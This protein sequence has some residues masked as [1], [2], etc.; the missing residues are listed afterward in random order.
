MPR[1][2]VLYTFHEMN[3]RVQQ[4][5]DGI[6]QSPDVDF[7]VISNGPVVAV[8]PY[9]K[10]IR[11]PNIGHDFGAWSDGLLAGPLTYEYYI[12]VNSSA[13]G[14]WGP[15]GPAGDWTTRFIAGLRNGVKLFGS[16]INVMGGVMGESLNTMVGAHVQSYAFAMDREAAAFLIEKGI[17]SKDY[18]VNNRVKIVEMKEVRMSRLII[19]N[20][21]NIGCL[22][23]CYEGV[24]F[25][26]RTEYPNRPFYTDIMYPC[27]EWHLWQ[28]VELVFMKG[29]R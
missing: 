4:F 20:G 24:D 16:T 8:P 3:K 9:V 26:G 11:R 7:L 23:K 6:F 28:R 2:L 15:R 29:N 13:S 21:W 10:F 17:F 14:P 22:L 19:E 5:L 25:S 18:I 12:F 1:T 27:F